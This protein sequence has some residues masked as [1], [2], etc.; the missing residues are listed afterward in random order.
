MD[1]SYLGMLGTSQS[2]NA[3]TSSQ[4]SVNGIPE[5]QFGLKKRA[6]CQNHQEFSDISAL[7]VWQG[8]QRLLATIA[9][10]KYLWWRSLGR[11]NWYYQW[12]LCRFE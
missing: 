8:L 1:V 7:R 4:K 11:M 5:V 3:R 10:Y 2:F 12:D 9:L 6:L